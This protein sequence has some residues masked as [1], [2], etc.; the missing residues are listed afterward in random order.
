MSVDVTDGS[1]LARGACARLA[2]VCDAMATYLNAFVPPVQYQVFP[3]TRTYCFKR[4][5]SS[6]MTSVKLTNLYIE[7]LLSYRI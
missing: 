1:P 3:S 5:L 4:G 7:A 2:L 6:Y